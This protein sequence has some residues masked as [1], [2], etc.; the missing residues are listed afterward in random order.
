[1]GGSS[2]AVGGDLPDTMD[3]RTSG[4][5]TKVKD[6]VCSAIHNVLTETVCVCVV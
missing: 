4:I 2:G 6:Q 1:M 5:V 3:W